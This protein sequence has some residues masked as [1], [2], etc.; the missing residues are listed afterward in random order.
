MRCTSYEPE[1]RTYDIEAREIHPTL[2]HVNPSLIS[3]KLRI[4][5]RAHL[6]CCH[7]YLPYVTIFDIKIIYQLTQTTRSHA[8]HGHHCHYCQLYA[9]IF[10]NGT[11]Y[12]SCL[13]SCIHV[14]TTNLLN[15]TCTLVAISVLLG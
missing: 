15:I 5:V 2:S 10:H 9:V 11:P 4:Q 3:H 8:S 6:H 12:T 14:N 1:P 13:L 7:I